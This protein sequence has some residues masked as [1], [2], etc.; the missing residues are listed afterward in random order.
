VKAM[1][2]I[3][4]GERKASPRN[5]ARVSECKRAMVF[6]AAPKAL[7]SF[8]FIAQRAVAG[9]GPQQ[10]R[11]IFVAGVPGLAAILLR[12]LPAAAPVDR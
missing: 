10:N 8:S 6:N 11:R 12:E 2:P 9:A 4:Q 5:S 7:L 1:K 3:N